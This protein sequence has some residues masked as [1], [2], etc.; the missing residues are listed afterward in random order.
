MKRRQLISSLTAFFVLLTASGTV[1]ADT[2]EAATLRVCA[3][4]NNLPYSNAAG[5]GFENRLAELLAQSMGRKV[6][7]TWWAQRRGFI[8]NTLKA[9]RCDVVMGLP[10]GF[11]EALTTHPYYQSS[12]A[13]VYRQDSKYE[14]RSLDDPRL[15]DLRVGVHLVGEGI[16]P[17]AEVL[18][19]H[20]VVRNV[21]GFSIFGDYSQ[22]N[23]PA[24]LI[25]AVSAG[26]ID[27]AVAWGPLAGYF[28]EQSH[29]PLTVVP[30]PESGNP[31]LPFRFDI[32][33]GVRPD[34]TQLRDELDALLS[35]K[36]P[37]IQALLQQYG[38]PLVNEPATV[39]QQETL[40]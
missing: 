25:D 22:P 36:Q 3:D 11:D 9:G 10:S 13:L 1:A 15:H 14:L 20:G 5:Q 4:P 33:M 2:K 29:T 21:V 17:P 27:V 24:R 34:D 19:R 39:S 8:R 7:Y 35:R 6:E 31:M 37:E 32:A 40:P 12:Y 16:S 26:E 18:A 38:I 30:L 28:A 23:P